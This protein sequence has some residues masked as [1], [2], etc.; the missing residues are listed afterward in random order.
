[1]LKIVLMKI[2]DL[3]ILFLKISPKPNWSGQIFLQK[4]SRRSFARN[5]A[6]YA[7]CE[8]SRPLPIKPGHLMFVYYFNASI[9]KE[10]GMY[11]LHK[12]ILINTIH[13]LVI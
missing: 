11:V 2:L 13:M 5:I 8:F 3:R 9:L 10:S 1:M 4:C 12:I 7:N 6:R